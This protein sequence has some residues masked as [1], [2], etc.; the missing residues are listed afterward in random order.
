MPDDTAAGK[1]SVAALLPDD[2]AH[3]AM[4]SGWDS[5]S[6]AP[7]DFSK[8]LNINA[9]EPEI[10]IALMLEAGASGFSS[11]CVAA[12]KAQSVI[13]LPYSI[14]SAADERYP[15]LA[16]RHM[17]AFISRPSGRSA[18]GCYGHVVY[19]PRPTFIVRSRAFVSYLDI[20]T[21]TAYRRYTG[22]GGIVSAVGNHRGKYSGYAAERR[23]EFY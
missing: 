23:R 10:E 9:R 7:I 19:G 14:G 18:A 22:H 15:I 5:G 1:F 12:K 20:E 3:H 2:I 8:S 11:L 13:T 16:L 4:S 6:A 21:F 17:P